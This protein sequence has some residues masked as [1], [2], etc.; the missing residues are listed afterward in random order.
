MP[1]AD[2]TFHIDQKLIQCGCNECARSACIIGFIWVVMF[3]QGRLMYC[4]CMQQGWLFYLNWHIFL[5]YKPIGSFIHCHYILKNRV[6]TYVCMFGHSLGLV[7]TLQF[8]IQMVNSWTTFCS[9]HKFQYSQPL[10]FLVI[11]GPMYVKGV[12]LVVCIFLLCSSEYSI[13]LF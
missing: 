9:L 4:F 2:Q 10:L 3:W 8:R 13:N 12:L 6:Y 5:F 11:F 1:M 7:C